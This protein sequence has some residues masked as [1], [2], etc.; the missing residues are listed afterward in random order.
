MKEICQCNCSL[1]GYR[2]PWC[3]LLHSLNGTSGEVLHLWYK[4][5]IVRQEILK[6]LAYLGN[7]DNYE[8]VPNVYDL[9]GVEDSSVTP[10]R[11]H[12]SYTV[13]D[14]MTEIK[15]RT[16]YLGK[17][18]RTEEATHLL[19]LIKMTEDEYDLFESFVREA[20]TDVWAVLSAPFVGLQKKAW[21]QA[22]STTDYPVGVHYDFD[23]SY[24]MTAEELV[25]LRTIV[26]E[27]LIERI[28]YKWLS[29]SYP[30]EA[31][32]YDTLFKQSLVTVRDRSHEFK[33]RW[34]KLYIPYAK[35]AMADVFEALQTYA[36]KQ[37]MAYFFNEGKT[38][39]TFDDVNAEG[40]VDS[41][42]YMYLPSLVN[43]DVNGYVPL[44]ISVDVNGYAT[45]QNEPIELVK[46]NKGDYVLY[47][48]NLYMAIADGSSEDYI[49]KLVPTE[50]YRGSIHY[51]IMWQCCT[52][53]INMVEPLD[54]SI[55]DALVARIIYKWLR[56]AYPVEAPRY[57][58]E[59][60]ENISL[61]RQRC[62]SMWG[63]KVVNRIP[64]I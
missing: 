28:I 46:F 37:E 57:L 12:L 13:S 63:V 8:G 23:V 43:M 47:N 38:T 53:N 61:V 62:N 1:T 16:A 18:R 32:A 36:P 44:N 56:D 35:S 11:F 50:D 6:R 5:D 17:F 59:W 33:A 51:G 34:S 58:E 4:L 20:M 60:N 39:V 64:R 41:D 10:M 27:A 24:N 31:A 54:T 3:D 15:R 55:F 22:T 19:D 30:S 9:V 2:T 21:W 52:S 45:F 40:S 25:P 42:G 48:G 14:L 49:G 26:L 29:L 7:S